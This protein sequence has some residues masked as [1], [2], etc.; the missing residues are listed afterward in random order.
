MKSLGVELMD[1]FPKSS[2]TGKQASEALILGGLATRFVR[3]RKELVALGGEGLAWEGALSTEAEGRVR[4]RMLSLDL[5]RTGRRME[6][7]SCPVVSLLT[8]MALNR[9]LLA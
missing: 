9:P 8:L 2:S 6:E 4:C 5:E 3:M 1:H 7:K